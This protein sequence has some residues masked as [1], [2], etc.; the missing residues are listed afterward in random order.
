VTHLFW[1]APR[2]PFGYLFE[3]DDWASVMG[4]A[5]AL[6]ELDERLAGIIRATNLPETD[7]Y[8]VDGGRFFVQLAEHDPY[9]LLKD[10]IREAATLTGAL[11][12]ESAILPITPSQLTEGLHPIP[13]RVVGVPGVTPYQARI[14]RYYKQANPAT[15]PTPE[16]FAAR[17]HFGQVWDRMRTLAQLDRFTASPTFAYPVEEILPFIERCPLCGIRPVEV[18]GGGSEWCG[19]CE[20]RISGAPSAP[21]YT[22]LI[23]YQVSGL[24]RLLAE[25]P[26][27]ELYRRTY[28]RVQSALE[29]ACVISGAETLYRAGD[30]GLLADRGNGLAALWKLP[31]IF[32]DHLRD[33]FKSLTLTVGAAAGVTPPSTLFESAGVALAAAV[34]SDDPGR[35]FVLTVNESG[36]RSEPTGYP[37]EG[38]RAL[39]QLTE[40]LRSIARPEGF[41][42]DLA[43]QLR[44]GT[45]GLYIGYG[46][47]RLAPSDR[48]TF[49]ALESQWG[50]GSAKFQRALN[51][52]LTLLTLSP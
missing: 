23:R 5:L 13:E 21:P 26:T 36:V 45:A 37:L 35:V 34:R 14:N 2:D 12:L 51:D 3:V 6:T 25:Q 20:K 11:T 46:R 4:G 47:I 7:V 52:A 33:Q 44:R 15:L 38:L 1:L 22:L 42:V 17:R 30:Q 19:V 10:A 24:D 28:R 9:P 16:Q 49:D 27:P 18:R 31:E 8:H 32:S 39:I 29:R 43:E 40:V 41:L 50:A 48:V